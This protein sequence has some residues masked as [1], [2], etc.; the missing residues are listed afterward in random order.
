MKVVF[1]LST[2]SFD[3]QSFQIEAKFRGGGDLVSDGISINDCTNHH[4]NRNGSLMTQSG[5]FPLQGKVIPMVWLT[6]S[7]TSALC[8]RTCLGHDRQTNCCP[9][10]S[11]TNGSTSRK[12]SSEGVKMHSVFLQ[13]NN[14]SANRILNLSCKTSKK[15]QVT[16]GCSPWRRP[17]TKIIDSSSDLQGPVKGSQAQLVKRG[18]LSRSPDPISA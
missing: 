7:L 13:I 1:S 2:S 18:A 3:S 6:G 10:I 4:I 14:A 8:N 9:P 15:P 5:R 17:G 12:N 16:R 11:P